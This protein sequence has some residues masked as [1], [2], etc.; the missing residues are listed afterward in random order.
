MASQH[1]GVTKAKKRLVVNA[2]VEMC[3]LVQ[4]VVA[5]IGSFYC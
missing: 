5:V 1:S 4:A 3:K 2:F